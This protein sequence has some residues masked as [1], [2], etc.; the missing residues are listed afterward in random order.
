MEQKKEKGN[1]MENLATVIVDKRNLFFLIYIF[2]AVFCV[3]S[4]NWTKVE[5]DVTRYLSEET[6]TR[7]GL[8]TMNEYFVSTSDARIMVSNISYEDAE[9]LYDLIVEVDGVSTVTFNDSEEQYKD[10]NA[11]FS[12]MFEEAALSGSAMNAL[13]EIKVIL[14]DY[15]VAYDT[16]V[17]YDENAELAN[18][19]AIILV[20]AVVIIVVA[21]VLTSTAYMEVPVL[22]LTFGA[23]ALLNMGTN[24]MLGTISFISDSIAVVLQLA[25]AIDY[26]IILAHRYSAE[27]ELLPTR[28]ACITALSKAIPEIAASSL[29]TI[30]GLAALGFMEFAIGLDMAIVLI[31]SILLS[32]LSVFT[33]MPGLLVLFDP[34]IQKTRHKKLLPDVSALGRFAVKSRKVVTP[35]FLV[36]IVVAFFFSNACPYCYSY[37]DLVTSNM[38]EKQEAYQKIK[39][40]FGTNNMVALLV[41]SG[42]YEAEAA[43]LAELEKYEAVK[44]TMGLAN[45]ELMDG[46]VLTD[47]LTAREFSE[48]M[49]IDYEVVEILYSAY[50]MQDEKYGQLL[51]MDTLEIPIFDLFCFLKDTMDESGMELEGEMAEMAD[52]LDMLDMAREQLRTDEYSR[53]VVYLTLPE[54]GDET[55]EFLT[56]I[57]NTAQQYYTEDVYVVGNSTSS[58]DLSSSFATDNLI[59]TILSIVFVIAVLLFTFQ[60]AGLPVLLIMVI[61]GSIWIN[62]A[63]PTITQE[64]LYFLGYLTV[65]AIQMGSNIDYAIVIS[66]HYKEQKENG[67][68]PQEAVVVAVNKA[69]PTIITS[70]TILA[71]AGFLLTIISTQPV[72]SILGGCIGR[73]T[74]ISMVLVLF[75][76]PGILVIGDKI[77][78]KTSFEMKG[79]EIGERE[80]TGT[81]MVKGHIRGY[82]SGV[83]DAEVDGVLH[84]R[85]HAAV[86]TGGTVDVAEHDPEA[87]D[88]ARTMFYKDATEPEENTQEGGTGNEE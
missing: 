39:G 69:F 13:D 72:I 54:E 45:T 83:L 21:L 84:G 17:G 14:K 37:T 18:Q 6:E 2:A 50:V 62:F 80:E 77:I 66:S 76:L 31:K 78:E 28:E 70:G 74:L 40:V 3:F 71:S 1:F 57:H 68:S 16:A 58:R 46:Y 41:P 11:L 81:M 52:M 86:A 20:V 64:P 8:D 36:V 75:V 79:I 59:I 55:Y 10:A 43:I 44:S 19:M 23:A 5:N 42:D 24:F 87:A 49:G 15:D 22:L 48:V 4:M 30:S 12:V 60:S 67:L 61:Q 26:A 63:V 34:L 65:N 9:D 32:L 85:V 33:L 38:S 7:Q 56:T 82:V 73:G 27:R 53:M 88:K 35:V 47:A 29:T 25:L 51:S